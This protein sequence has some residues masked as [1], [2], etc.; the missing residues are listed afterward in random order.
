MI[1]SIGVRGPDWIYYDKPISISTGILG[2][3]IETKDGIKKYSTIAGRSK[4]LFNSFRKPTKEEAEILYKDIVNRI[5]ID[6]VNT[7]FQ[8]NRT[9]RK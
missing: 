6:F 5:Y 9:H 1:G 4:D 8:N 3:A 7:V 2:Q